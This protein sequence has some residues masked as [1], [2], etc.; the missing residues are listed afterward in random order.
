[1]DYKSETVLPLSVEQWT[2]MH[3]DG[4]GYADSARKM[5]SNIQKYL[6]IQR[7]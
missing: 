6:L 3:E 5:F 7:F 4:L 2:R 1:M